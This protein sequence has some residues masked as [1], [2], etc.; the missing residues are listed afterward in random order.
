MCACFKGHND[1][2]L[3]G[4]PCN[5]TPHPT[6][7]TETSPLGYFYGNRWRMTRCTGVSTVQDFRKCLKERTLIIFGDSTTR[8]WYGSINDIMQGVQ[9][10]EKWITSKWFKASTS[11][12]REINFTVK[13]IPNAQPLYT[14][15]SKLCKSTPTI[16]SEIGSDENVI[17]VLHM[18]AHLLFYHNDVF[19]D[20]IRKIRQAVSELLERNKLAVIAIKGPHHFNNHKDINDYMGFVFTDILRREFAELRER[21]IYLDQTDMTT[22]GCP[23][24]H[25]DNYVVEQ[26]VRTMFALVF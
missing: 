13:W 19:R 24:I 26:M 16:L 5:E 3:P 12:N 2:M 17:I 6:T 15:N 11:V 9:T 4:Q 1:V 22:A 7:W 20:R 8:Q 21:V 18:Y 14:I 23:G 25:P 10:S